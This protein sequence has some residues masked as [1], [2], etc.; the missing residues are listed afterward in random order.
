MMLP[1]RHHLRRVDP[2]L[3]CRRP[4]LGAG[5]GGISRRRY[6]AVADLGAAAKL[7]EASF[8]AFLAGR[9]V[10]GR[11]SDHH[12]RTTDFLILVTPLH[13]FLFIGLSFL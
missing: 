7:V 10:F 4:D 5:W 1:R 11:I 3:G 8:V 9:R 13:C 6:L 2:A 12:Q